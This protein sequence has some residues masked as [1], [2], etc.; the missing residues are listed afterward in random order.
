[1]ELRRSQEETR[2]FTQEAHK[3]TAE[4]MKLQAEELKV[5]AEDMKLRRDRIMAPWQIVVTA[6]GAGAALFAAGAAFIKVFGH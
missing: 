2:K 3:L 5:R 1:M 6:M 4:A